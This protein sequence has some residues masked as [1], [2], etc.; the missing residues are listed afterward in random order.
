MRISIVIPSLDSMVIGE[1]VRSLL[2]QT[3][4]DRIAEILVVGMDRPGLVPSEDLVQFVSTSQP[5][6]A[7]TARN[8]GIR[9]AVGDGM[10]FLDSDCV[11]TPDWLERLLA[12]HA[13]G[14]PVVSGSVALETEDYVSLCYNLSLFSDV[15]T[16]SPA[17]ERDSVPSLSLSVTREVIDRVGLFDEDLPRSHDVD[18]CCRIRRAGYPIYFTPDAAVYHWPRPASWTAMV[19]KFFRS[20]FYSSSVR[21]AYPDLMRTPW[22]FSRPLALRLLSPLVAAG[23]TIRTFTRNRDMLRYLHTAPIVWT[24][25]MA[26]CLGASKQAQTRLEHSDG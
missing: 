2:A 11:A 17:G 10:V 16:L 7:S 24:C 4:R 26:W 14:H 6:Y 1:T 20:G 22:F 9:R 18:W 5:V 19:H 23:T 21:L 3:R 12:C 15:L 8:I 25:K 13:R